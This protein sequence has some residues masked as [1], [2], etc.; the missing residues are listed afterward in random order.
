MVEGQVTVNYIPGDVPPG[1]LIRKPIGQ[2]ESAGRR[3]YSLRAV[4][5]LNAAT[6]V[7][8]HVSGSS[9]TDLRIADTLFK[10]AFIKRRIGRYTAN[11]SLI[12]GQ[13]ISKQPSAIVNKVL[14]EVSFLT[15]AARL[16][17]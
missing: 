2:V 16:R 17:G 4:L 8:M 15:C 9:S 5:G 3:G 1:P 12:R 7:A 11:R 14:L 10:Q 13:T 6:Y